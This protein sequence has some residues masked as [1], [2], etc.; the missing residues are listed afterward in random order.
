MVRHILLTASIL[1]LVSSGA[2]A[3]FYSI[4]AG[5]DGVNLHVSNFIPA[6]PAPV[7]V[8]PAPVVVPLRPGFVMP[9]SPH[10][11][12]KAIKKHVKP[13]TRNYVTAHTTHHIM[14]LR[15]WSTLTMTIMTTTKTISRISTKHA[16]SIQEGIQALQKGYEKNA[17]SVIIMTTD[18]RKSNRPSLS[19]PV[20]LSYR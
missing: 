6:I 14:R 13:T 16:K 9:P 17:T 11:Y 2:S 8:A 3:Q 12:H 10:R 4:D 20:Y 1:G 19:R 7:V 15:Q 5:T 18:R